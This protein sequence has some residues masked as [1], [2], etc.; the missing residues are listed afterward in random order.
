MITSNKHPNTKEK[1]IRQHYIFGRCCV[2]SFD[3]L[4]KIMVLSLFVN[5]TNWTH[6]YPPWFFHSILLQPQKKQP[7]WR[8][9]DHMRYVFTKHVMYKKKIKITLVT[10]VL[11][12]WF[13]KERKIK[14][15]IPDLIDD[16]REIVGDV[17]K[18]VIV[19]FSWWTKYYFFFL[20]LGLS[21]G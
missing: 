8:K 14:K 15:I 13:L 16:R 7:T 20:F 9:K 10:V 4:M 5:I 1:S 11:I 6:V 18:Q 3:P 19:V 2:P 17:G 12:K 21:G